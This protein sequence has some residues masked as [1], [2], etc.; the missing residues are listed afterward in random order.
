MANHYLFYPIVYQFWQYTEN[1]VE[2]KAQCV[3][4]FERNAFVVIKATQ[5]IFKL[6]KIIVD[7]IKIKSCFHLTLAPKVYH[8]LHYCVQCNTKITDINCWNTRIKHVGTMK[9]LCSCRLYHK[10][11]ALGFFCLLIFVSLT[12]SGKPASPNVTAVFNNH[13]R[14][15][16]HDI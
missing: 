4:I 6:Q 7:T 11:K 14:R 1:S 13:Y 9:T 2:K 15:E 12:I 3:S 16:K 10:K 8:L 5:V